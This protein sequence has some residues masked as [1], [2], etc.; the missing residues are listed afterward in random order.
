MKKMT[1]QDWQGILRTMQKYNRTEG[2]VDYIDNEAIF[3]DEDPCIG[4]VHA[5]H[6]TKEDVEK[7]IADYDKDVA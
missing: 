7:Y 5:C 6:V 1:K 3:F 4:G 2:Y